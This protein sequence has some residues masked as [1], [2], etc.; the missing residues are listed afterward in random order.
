MLLTKKNENLKISA[1]IFSKSQENRLTTIQQNYENWIAGNYI[2]FLTP[3]S[4]STSIKGLENN[5]APLKTQTE[6][7]LIYPGIALKHVDSI[8]LLE[9]ITTIRENGFAGVSFFAIEQLDDEKI[10]FLRIA[11]FTLPENDPTYSP[12]NTAKSIMENYKTTLNTIKT[13]Y[14]E[15]KYPQKT[16]LDNMIAYA[17]AV[18]LKTNNNQLTSAITTLK[19]L[20][21]KNEKFFKDLFNYNKVRKQAIKS[22]LKRAKN[23]LK[24]ADKR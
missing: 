8:D 17:N 11:N 23:L 1:S 18:I 24:I 7:S 10:N 6:Y 15:L 4:Y 19:E 13:N 22:Y 20:E 12:V 16:E 2:D 21:E 14:Y 3:M 9:Q 5:L